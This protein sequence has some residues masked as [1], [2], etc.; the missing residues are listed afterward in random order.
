MVLDLPPSTLIRGAADSAQIT[1]H[2]GL[3]SGY[4]FIFRFVLN[5]CGLLVL[6]GGHFRSMISVFS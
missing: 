2:V 4:G 1:I 5:Q 3:S 6:V